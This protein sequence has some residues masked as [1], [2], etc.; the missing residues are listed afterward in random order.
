MRTLT[1]TCSRQWAVQP[2]VPRERERRREQ[3]RRQA[4]A[5]EHGGGVVL[6]VRLDRVIGLVLGQDAKRDLLD[7]HGLVEPVGHLGLALGHRAQRGG[8]RVVRSV[9]AMPE[10]HQPL[11][12]REGRADPGLGLVDRAHLVQLVDDLG[13]R[14]P[15]PRSLQGAD[16][17]GHRAGDVRMRRD[18]HPRR[19][20]GGVESMFGAD[21]E[22]G[23]E[24]TGRRRVGPLAAELVQEPLGQAQ[25]RVGIDRLLAVDAG[26]RTRPAR[27]CE[28]RQRARLLDGRRPQGAVTAPHAETA[29]RRAS[30]G[31]AVAGRRRRTSR[32]APAGARRRGAHR[33]SSHPSTAAPRPGR[34][35][36]LG[37]QLA[38]RIAPILEAAAVAVDHG[39]R[40]LPGQDPLQARRERAFGFIHRCG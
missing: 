28:R 14:A 27:W 13:R 29:V 5:L 36:P 6:D 26:G 40:R 19:E 23:V 31:L 9:H 32:P 8:A 20:G 38:D 35:C 25:R 12:A 30:I 16:G 7:R 1:A 3:V 10:A 34:T 33:P 11:A 37:H 39:Q 4:D 21:H 24:G 2:G 15:V 18:D 17:T 22:V